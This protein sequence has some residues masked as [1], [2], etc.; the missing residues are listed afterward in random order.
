MGGSGSGSQGSGAVPPDKQVP[1]L[2]AQAEL[3]K[4]QARI[5][6]Y[7]EARAK[8]REKERL[9]AARKW[10]ADHDARIKAAFER[11]KERQR[12]LD[13]VDPKFGVKVV[14][15]A[16]QHW[17]MSQS[18]QS[19]QWSKRAPNPYGSWTTSVITNKCNVFVYHVLTQAGLPVPLVTRESVEWNG[20]RLEEKSPPL[21]N[22][23]ADPNFKIPHWEVVTI[24]REGDIAAQRGEGGSGHVGIVISGNRTISQ[25]SD[26]D[27]V[28]DTKWGF[29]DENAGKMVFRRYV[30]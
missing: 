29:R 18:S 27:L 3:E 25:S 9:E 10:Q 1:R 21:A 22:E 6:G 28:E 11:A 7:A 30:P 4:A 23:W 20:K 14:D 26:T 15:V 16:Q 5:R 8:E 19:S 13:G 24:P 17:R 2:D 12:L